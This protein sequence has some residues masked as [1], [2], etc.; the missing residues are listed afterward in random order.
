MVVVVGAHAQV[1]AAR[2]TRGADSRRHRGEDPD[3]MGQLA[4]HGLPVTDEV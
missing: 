2:P 3:G 1:E 4:F